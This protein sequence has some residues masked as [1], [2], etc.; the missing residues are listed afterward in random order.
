MVRGGRGCAVSVE[1]FVADGRVPSE[2]CDGD[3]DKGERKGSL[4]PYTLE[5]LR[6]SGSG[7]GWDC[8]FDEDTLWLYEYSDRLILGSSIW[9]AGVACERFCPINRG[10]HDKSGPTI[11]LP[12]GSMLGSSV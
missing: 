2:R 4:V 7:V 8:T 10:D 6:P 12:D 1:I 9:L 11:G 5:G 3:E